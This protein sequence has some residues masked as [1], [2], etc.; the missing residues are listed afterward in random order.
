MFCAKQEPMVTIF[1]NMDKEPEGKEKIRM[2]GL[3]AWDELDPADK[4]K[5]EAE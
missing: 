2:L 4:A 5:L 1:K 3:D